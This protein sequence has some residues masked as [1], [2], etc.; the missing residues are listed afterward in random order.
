MS[1]RKEKL[2]EALK[3]SAAE[4]LKQEANPSPLI[5]VTNCSI[6]NDMRHA[7]I[8]VTVIPSEKEAQAITF[9]RRKRTPFRDYLKQHTRMH[10]IPRIDFAI[11]LGERHR[12][13]I[14]ELL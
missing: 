4:F 13:K 14:D 5:T 9:L 11:D 12:Q 6:S 7:T 1:E 3:R 2:T 8:F 10:I